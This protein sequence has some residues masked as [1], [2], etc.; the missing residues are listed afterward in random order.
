MPSF[1]GSCLRATS[2]I[3]SCIPEH[4]YHL[5]LQSIDMGDYNMPYPFF[6]FFREENYSGGL[7]DSTVAKILL[8]SFNKQRIPFSNFLH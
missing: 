7:S 8:G 4:M 5:C 1:M 2:L 6:F 3:Q